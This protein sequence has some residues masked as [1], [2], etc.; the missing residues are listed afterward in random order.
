MICWHNC[1]AQSQASVGWEYVT[2]NDFIS[3]LSGAPKHGDCC[4]KACHV[5]SGCFSLK[6]IIQLPRMGAE[7]A[8][9]GQDPLWTSQI[10]LDVPRVQKMF[11]YVRESLRPKNSW[12]SDLV[13]MTASCSDTHSRGGLSAPLGSDGG[14]LPPG[15]PL[16]SWCSSTRSSGTSPVPRMDA[17]W[18]EIG[19]TF[20]LHSLSAV[21]L[22][23][24]LA[25][26][27]HA[28]NLL[29]WGQHLEKTNGMQ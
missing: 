12:L 17:S 21:V 4:L 14:F 9:R 26:M 15:L 23:L 19:R 8:G 29:G 25:F 6:T 3:S 20:A 7:S 13:K 16:L 10:F 27:A 22:E 18:S 1:G 2:E 11:H 28:V 24:W 5:H